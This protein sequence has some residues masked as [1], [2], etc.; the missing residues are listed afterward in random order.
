[1]NARSLTVR[2]ADRDQLVDSPS[3]FVVEG[4][5]PGEPVE[6][7]ATLSLGGMRFASEAVFA[8]GNEGTVDTG[9]DAPTSGSYRGADPFGLLWSGRLVGP[10]SATADGPAIVELDVVASDIRASDDH[11]DVARE[12]RHTHPCA[13]RGSARSVRRGLRVMGR[14]LRSSRS[15]ARAVVCWARRCG[16][17][18]WPRTGSRR[19]RSRTSAFPGCRLSSSA[20]RSRSCSGPW[21]GC[22]PA[23]RR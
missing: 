6:I 18:F 14:S 12:G 15:E 11:A 9:R 22:E 10:A 7:A 2:P 17:H 13:Y 23:R 20:S 1:M 16:H 3:G 5:R 8:A 4:C 19:W 21:V